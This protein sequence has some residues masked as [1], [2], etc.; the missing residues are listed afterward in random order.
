[1]AGLWDIAVGSNDPDAPPR[2]NVSLLT[3]ELTGI[4]L[5]HRTTAEARTSLETEFGRAFTGNAGTIGT[6]L[7]DLNA[8]AA[9]INQGAVQ[10]K[11]VYAHSMQ[12]ALN[13]AEL[14][15]IDE[16]TFRAALNIPLP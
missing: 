3:T 15:L 5:G 1:M 13:A 6:E 14:Q 9:E 11:L 12:W 7:G 4:A 16:T 2:I 10:S 8:L